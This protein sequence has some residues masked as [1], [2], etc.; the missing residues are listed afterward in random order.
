PSPGSVSTTRTSALS[1]YRWRVVIGPP[2]AHCPPKSISPG[3][4]TWASLPYSSHKSAVGLNVL[5]AL[6]SLRDYLLHSSAHEH[7]TAEIPYVGPAYGRSESDS[8]APRSGVLSEPGP[9]RSR[10]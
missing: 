3:V 1:S 4:M 10:S 6:C 2:K 5:I 8:P 7:T 9:T